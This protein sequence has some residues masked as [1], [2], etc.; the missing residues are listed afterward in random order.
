MISSIH[1]IIAK[2]QIS[3]RVISAKTFLVNGQY[4]FGW[5]SLI[6]SLT[7]VSPIR[8]LSQLLVVYITAFHRPHFTGVYAG[9]IVINIKS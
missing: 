7:D 2:V 3:A 9:V 8:T 5:R 1:N 4:Q 6:I